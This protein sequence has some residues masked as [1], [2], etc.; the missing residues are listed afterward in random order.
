M[1][2]CVLANSGQAKNSLL[3]YFDVHIGHI[4]QMF[5]RF[6]FN[7]VSLHIYIHIYMYICIYVYIYIYIYMYIYDI[8]NMYIYNIYNTYNIICMYVQ[9]YTII[10]IYVQLNHPSKFIQNI[11]KLK[12]CVNFAWLF[13]S[14]RGMFDK[15]RVYGFL[16]Y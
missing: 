2:Y 4:W 6:T 13:Y 16:I 15:Y 8:Y 10:Y 11:H 3:K 1:H 12:T 14:F 7:T 5:P 9:L